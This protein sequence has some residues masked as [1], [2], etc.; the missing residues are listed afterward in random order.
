MSAASADNAPKAITPHAKNNLNDMA[1]S[2]EIDV[3][4]NWEKRFTLTQTLSF[5]RPTR[6][7]KRAMLAG[8]A[9]N[10]GLQTF[11]GAPMAVL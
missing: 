2:F 8:T 3:R 4:W 9:T 5:R 7:G 6:Q 10:H 1:V 11:P